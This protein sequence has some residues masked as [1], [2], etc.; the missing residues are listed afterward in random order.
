MFVPLFATLPIHCSLDLQL[1][2]PSLAFFSGELGGK[3]P[4]FVSFMFQVVSII[5]TKRCGLLMWSIDVASWS[6]R[7]FPGDFTWTS[8]S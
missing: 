1:Y 7:A 2:S 6:S 8:F 3:F 4:L 5:V